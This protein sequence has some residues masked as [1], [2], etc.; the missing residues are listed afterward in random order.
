MEGPVNFLFSDI[1][2]IVIVDQIFLLNIP[3][4]G[5][6]ELLELEQLQCFTRRRMKEVLKG[7]RN[8]LRFYRFLEGN[9]ISM[10]QNLNFK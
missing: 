6:S 8:L 7:I 5:E 2:W 9:Y 10:S 1:E 4:N 3:E